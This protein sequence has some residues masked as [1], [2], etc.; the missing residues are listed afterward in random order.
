MATHGGAPVY[1]I[2]LDAFD[3]VLL[4][5]WAAEGLLL[6][7]AR[8]LDR[9]TR[10]RLTGSCRVMQGSIWPTVT[11]ARDP[12]AHGMYYMLQPRPGS[13]RLRRVRADDLRAPPFWEG[14]DA[15]GKRSLIIDVPKLGLRP[16]AHGIQV[17][18]WGATDHYSRFATHPRP[19]RKALLARYGRHVLQGGMDC[20]VSDADH[21]ALRDGLIAG[22]AAKTRLLTDLIVEHRPDFVFCVYGEAHPAGHHFWRFHQDRASHPELG[23]ALQRVYTALDQAIGTLR[24]RFGATANLL[25]FTGHGMT[26]DHYPRWLM[27]PVLRRMGLEVTTGDRSRRYPRPLPSATQPTRRSAV[28][29]RLRQIANR[30]LIPRPIQQR[31]WLHHLQQGIDFTHSRAWALPTDLQGFVRINLE[32]REPRGSVAADELAGLLDRIDTELLRLVNATTAAPFVQE[33][34]R[35]GDR[36][37]DSPQRD[38]LPDLCV[39]WRNAP[40]RRV[41]SPTLGD[42]EAPAEASGASEQRSGNHRL[43]GT[44]IALGPDIRPYPGR[45]DMDLRDIGPTVLA[46]L[47]VPIPVE[48]KGRPLCR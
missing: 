3:P 2:G 39:L 47:D 17:V 28:P 46:L 40:V 21:L 20:P 5:R 33:T 6:N 10:V 43:E 26:T 16:G 37:A 12:G 7:I 15:A 4:T 9:G 11:T 41:H 19:L 18:E 14:L 35:P 45:G 13:H 36:Y 22:V 32:G 29:P 44:L 23:S 38:H 24:K 30:Y 48:F 25:L 1:L 8:L 27:R 31:L 42:F 34:F